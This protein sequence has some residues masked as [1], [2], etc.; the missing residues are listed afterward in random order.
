MD[1]NTIVINNHFVFIIIFS[2]IN[3][4]L[5]S[6]LN[7]SLSSATSQIPYA[8]LSLYY[9]AYF[10]VLG[11]FVPYW[12]I[13]L[14]DELGFSAIQIGQLMAVFMLSKIIA[15]LVWSS[16]VDYTQKRLFLV[17]L[18][19]GLT[20]LC[21]LGVYL[22]NHFIWLAVVVMGFGFFWNASLPTFESITLNHLGEQSQRYSRIR[23]WGS[24][25]FITMA[26]GLPWLFDNTNDYLL[27]VI[28]LGFMAIFISTWLVS[29]CPKRVALHEGVSLKQVLSHPLVWGLLLVGALQ[30]AS[31][32]AYYNFYSL[33]LSDYGYEETHIG[34]LWALGVLAEVILF[35]YMHRLIERYGAIPLFTLSVL[36]TA[37]RWA[38]MGLWVDNVWM[39]TLNQLFHA[40]SYA[41]FHA[42]GIYMLHHYI[43]AAFQSL[44]QALYIAISFGLGGA[45]GS[46]LSGYTWE[47][48]GAQQTFYWSAALALV[49]WIIALQFMRGSQTYDND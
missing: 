48:Q 16:L 4:S 37:L 42:T 22:G 30:Q 20:I 29:D 33:Y 39:V 45:L 25:G 9:F 27:E 38:V 1:A 49:A 32:G 3:D 35:L 19:A 2:F 40:A 12:T 5:I 14:R 21:F 13:Y 11:A 18:A 8:R 23:L 17:R 46:L 6:L 41:L 44:G 34:F 47:W 31:H 28:L 15:P 36:L 43:P 26:A 10:A 24:I 7:T